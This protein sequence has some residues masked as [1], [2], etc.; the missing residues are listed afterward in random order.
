MPETSLLIVTHV[1]SIR[2]FVSNA[3]RSRP[4]LQVVGVAQN[5]MDAYNQ[6][7]EKT[8]QLV[9]IAA[10]MTK[11]PE[12]EMLAALFSALDIRWLEITTDPRAMAQGGGRGSDLFP[13]T[14]RDSPTTLL[15]RIDALRQ[16]R[17]SALKAAPA[18]AP[19]TAAKSS[20]LILIGSSTGGVEAL[21]T[22]LSS[23]PDNCPPTLIVQ[24]TGETFGGS[25]VRLL[26]GRTRA[27]VVAAEDGMTVEPGMV[28]IAAGARKHMRMKPNAPGRISLQSGAPVSGHMPSVD[29][30]MQSAVPYAGRIAAAILTG[31]GRDGAD[32]LKALR[33][34]GARTF[35]QDESSSVV[36]GMPRVAWEEGAAEARV[37]LRSMTAKLLEA[38]PQGLAKSA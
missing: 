23:F 18:A 36:Y 8:P 20:K 37:P 38:Q 3:T 31:M 27:R 14:S 33:K 32:G 9:I 7:E 10:E 24:H 25:L 34:G 5:L 2:T 4:D 6:A 15:S 30:L 19:S 26:N 11:L 35:A 1:P 21:S 22:L 12:F 17:R 28:C 16:A 29:A 13:L